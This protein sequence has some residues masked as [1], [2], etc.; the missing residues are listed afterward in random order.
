M[1]SVFY[2]FFCGSKD[3][4]QFALYPLFDNTN[5]NNR[6]KKEKKNINTRS[7]RRMNP[8]VML[9]GNGFIGN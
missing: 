5:K 2:F 4:K 6:E 7:K 3:Y 1:D 9:F 8:N